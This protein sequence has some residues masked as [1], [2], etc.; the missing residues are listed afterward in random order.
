MERVLSRQ[1]KGGASMIELHQLCKTYPSGTVAMMDMNLI[2]KPGEFVFLVGSSGAGK[3]TLIKLLLREDTPTSGVLKVAGQDVNL[4][5]E[6]EVPY[7]RRSLGV[8]FQDFRLLP[9]KTVYENIAFAME[10]IG[11]NRRAVIHRVNQVLDLVGLRS[12]A[13]SY[14]AQLSG[15]E[16][17]RIAIARAIVNKPVLVIADEPTGNLD[18]ETS[19]EIMQI[20]EK[21]NEDGTTIVM[22]THDRPVVDAMQKRV[23]AIE[24]GQIIRDEEKGSYGYE[25][26]E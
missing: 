19:L 4:L 8:I 20:F 22:V 17:Q 21:I 15:G 26:C 9:A 10:V 2:I 14:P 16:Q 24:K 5:S 25:H 1:K 6:K 11:A 23:V 7:Y 13:R 12:K 3:S 18:P